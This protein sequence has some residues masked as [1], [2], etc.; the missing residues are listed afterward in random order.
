MKYFHQLPVLLLT[1]ALLGGCTV[2]PGTHFSSS[3]GTVVDQYHD[4]NDDL[5]EL[6]DIY[7]ITAAFIATAPT[8]K[9]TAPATDQR[10]RDQII[11]YEYLVGPGDVLSVTVWDHPEL[12]T[13]AG[14]Y[15][16]SEEAGSWVHSDGTIFYP[17]IGRVKVAGLN[18]SQ[19]RKLLSQRLGRVIE[20]PQI[21]VTIAAFRSKWVYV[22]GEVT[23]P[24]TLPITNIPLTL[25]DAVNQTGG[26]TE[27]ADWQ[28]VVLNRGEQHYRFS[29]RDLYKH[30]DVSQNMLLQ[31]NDVVHISRNDDNKVFV[32]GE[33]NRAQTLSM[34]RNGKTLAEALSDA[35]GINQITAD[36][37]GV[38]VMR[39]APQ[40]SGRI[41]D[42]YQL[43]VKN[44]AAM[45]LADSFHLQER[46]IVYVTAAPITRW[47]RVLSQLLPT[48]SGLNVVGNAADSVSGN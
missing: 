34:E 3:Y 37:T 5:S 40:N 30:G 46:D 42:V 33:V 28:S 8:A 6:V 10:L 38:F 17:Y 39:K 4:Q 11:N 18:I 20:S 13:P 29:L 19:I 23:Q 7:P 48:V 36:A 35:N 41:A 14:Q 47:N 22:T 26:L 45:V 24:G 16:S 25:L 15:R 2:I 44:M 27:A 1:T 12:T 43:N 32:L 9:P 31:P 21:D